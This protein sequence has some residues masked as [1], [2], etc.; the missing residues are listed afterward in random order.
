MSLPPRVVSVLSLV[1]VLFVGMGFLV[2]RGFIHFYEVGFGGYWRAS[3]VPA[4]PG[5][6]GS[7]GLWFFL[8][9]IVW[10][11]VAASR[12]RI[13][14][15]TSVTLLDFITGIV[16]TVALGLLFVMSSLGAMTIDPI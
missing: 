12:A 5:F 14:E 11:V 1:Q 9:P 8:V 4:L 7:Y 16:L 13:A 6:V 3:W 15:T 10:C 2:T